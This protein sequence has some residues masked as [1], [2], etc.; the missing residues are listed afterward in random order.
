MC[1]IV[2]YY[3]HYFNKYHSSTT[4][5]SSN[6]MTPSFSLLNLSNWATSSV[7][8]FLITSNLCGSSSKNF[9]LRSRTSKL[10]SWTVVRSS[11]TYWSDNISEWIPLYQR[12]SCSTWLRAIL[13]FIS[14]WKIV[15]IFPCFVSKSSEYFFNVTTLPISFSIC[16]MLGHDRLWQTC[17]ER[18]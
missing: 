18:K 11:N 17:N 1:Y 8:S 13:L 5:S 6:A 10:F 7:V 4:M 9:L 12:V 14:S 3:I 16:S 15:I 2:Q